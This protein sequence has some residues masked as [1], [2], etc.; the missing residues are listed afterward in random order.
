MIRKTTSSKTLKNWTR[1]LSCLFMLA[2]LLL[3][4]LLIKSF[5]GNEDIELRKLAV[6]DIN[7]D[8]NISAVDAR[9]L[10]RVSASLQELSPTQLSI[11]T[12]VKVFG[13][14]NGDSKISATDARALL[15]ISAKLHDI[16]EILPSLFTDVEEPNEPTPSPDLDKILVQNKLL[17]PY[18]NHGLG[19]A[20]MLMT[21]DDYVETT[22]SADKNV[23][24]HPENSPLIKGTIDYFIDSNYYKNRL[25]YNLK[26]G[27]KVQ[28]KSEEGSQI[29]SN[30]IIYSKIIEDGYKMPAN[31]LKFMTSVSSKNSTDLYIRPDWLIPINISF[32]PISYFNGY[33][34][35]PWNLKAFSAQYM[36]IDFYYTK[37]Y[38]GSLN[39]PKDSI[40]SKG[41]WL[42]NSNKETVTLRLYFNDAGAFLGYDISLTESGYIKISLKNKSESLDGKIIVF[43]PGHGGHDPGTVSLVDG[44]TGEKGIVLNIAQKAAEILRQRG[45]EV[46]LT[47]DDDCFLTLRERE[48]VTREI[49]PDAFV[50]IHCNSHTNGTPYGAETYYYYPFS[51]PLADSLQ[52]FIVSTYKNNIYLDKPEMKNIDRGIRYYPFYVT[53]VENCPSVLLELGFLSNSNDFYALIN[54]DNQNTLA[55]AIADGITEYFGGSNL[56]Q[57]DE[58]SDKERQDEGNDLLPLG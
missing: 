52:N 39:F 45:A 17:S 2:L 25:F 13:D 15:R 32:A 37:S 9:I 53:R 48:D 35:R 41:E 7:N 29:K 18:E 6:C 3:S 43:D 8:A 11:S 16:S 57:N 10:L 26:S 24:S 58:Q 5:A 54:L 19:S 51:M 56:N 50:S 38:S 30:D 40:I 1:R 49:N 33:G 20:K 44:K 22:S 55:M 47:R 42:K 28:W 4:P 23:F 21:I 46:I 14:I 36:D 31:T 27:R 12:G 34:N